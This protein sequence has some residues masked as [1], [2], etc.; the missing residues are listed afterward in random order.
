[1]S[2]AAGFFML[3]SLTVK[4]FMRAKR[5]AV[6]SIRKVFLMLCLLS[7]YR[8]RNGDNKDSRAKGSVIIFSGLLPFIANAWQTNCHLLTRFRYLTVEG[9]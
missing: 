9:K 2:K 3:N 5:G 8:G 4:A 1:M 6:F 7:V